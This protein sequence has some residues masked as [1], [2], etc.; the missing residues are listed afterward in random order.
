MVIMKLVMVN[1]FGR[2]HAGQYMQQIML[3]QTLTKTCAICVS[4]RTSTMSLNNPAETGLTGPVVA[5]FMKSVLR[6]TRLTALAK[7]GFVIIVWIFLIDFVW[8]LLPKVAC[9]FVCAPSSCFWYN[10]KLVPQCRAAKAVCS[11][12]ACKGTES[13]AFVRERKFLGG[14][15]N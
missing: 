4:N 14:V 13:K 10:I 2:S 1:P 6:I 5:G 11:A 15:D 9:V 8:C 3:S 7:I 12:V